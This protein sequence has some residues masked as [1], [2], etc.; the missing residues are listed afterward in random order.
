M[1]NGNKVKN[2]AADSD[3]NVLVYRNF[4]KTLTVSLF[5]LVLLAALLLKDN[6]LIAKTVTDDCRFNA[7][8]ACFAVSEDRI[9]IDFLA[10]FGVDRRN[11][12]RLAALNSKLLT[13]GFDDRVT[14]FHSL[15]LRPRSGK[16]LPY[17]RKT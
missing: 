15:A 5:A 14:H 17:S 13:A 10:C 16:L 2:L 3:K 12:E 4:R 9:D 8:C 7:C 11:A 6:D 1:V